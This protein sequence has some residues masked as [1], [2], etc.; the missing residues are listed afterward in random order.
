MVRCPQNR[1][2]FVFR[3]KVIACHPFVVIAAQVLHYELIIASCE[4][5][6]AGV[7][8]RTG[9]YKSPFGGLGPR[10]RPLSTRTVVPE[11]SS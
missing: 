6:A 8:G 2:T 1:G 3:R 10:D 5:G 4:S 9:R 7:K 11:R